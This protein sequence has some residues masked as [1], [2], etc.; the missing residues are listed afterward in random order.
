[1]TTTAEQWAV[2]TVGLMNAA[3][4]EQ[5]VAILEQQI[6][7]LLE[8]MSAELLP[9]LQALV[10]VLRAAGV[11]DSEAEKI[12]VAWEQTFGKYLSVENPVGMDGSASWVDGT[13]VT[14]LAYRMDHGE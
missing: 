8:Q 9:K 6:R 3:P 2:A 11:T 7:R 12:L 4:S 13:Y 1:M 14:L 10:V 5:S